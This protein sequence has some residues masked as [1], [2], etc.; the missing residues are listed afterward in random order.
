MCGIFANGQVIVYRWIERKT[1]EETIVDGVYF[2]NI[3]SRIIL[4]LRILNV[5]SIFQWNRQTRTF[6]F[7]HTRKNN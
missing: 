1:I 7:E 4:S 2:L 3:V 6:A 5:S